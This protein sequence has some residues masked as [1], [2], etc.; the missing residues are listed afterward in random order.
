VREKGLIVALDV[1]DP[2]EARARVGRLGSSVDFV[3]V[4]P[5]LALKDTELIPWLRK[6]RK[7]IFL[8]CKWYDI[9]SQVRRSVEA[10]GRMGVTSCT[11]HAGAGPAVIQAAVAARPK[12]LIWAVTVL[13]SFSDSD[14]RKVGVESRAEA[15]VVRLARLAQSCGVD[16]I[17]CSPHE[18]A[19][20]RRKG[21]KV[22]LVTPGIRFGEAGGASKDQKRTSGP[23]KAWA[24]GADYIVVGRSV[25][26]AADPAKAVRD[27][28]KEKPKPASRRGRSA[29]K[30]KP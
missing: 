13:T 15:Q 9:P 23:G 19:A 12:P 10:A 1:E 30:G 26:E 3:K 2:A 28:L 14:L 5:T 17:V 11:I 7:K 25:L 24:A 20:L 21:I 22:T 29:G 4:P 18:A 16:G 6:R 8:D 27:I